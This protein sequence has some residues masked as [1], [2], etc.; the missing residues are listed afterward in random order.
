MPAQWFVHAAPALHW[1]LFCGATFLSGIAVGAVGIGG[2]FLTP[3]LIL[4]GVPAKLATTAVLTSLLPT[5]FLLCVLYWRRQQ[6]HRAGALCLTCGA[7]PG[8]ALGTA[9]LQV[10]PT[11]AMVVIVGVVASLSGLQVLAGILHARLQRRR[12]PSAQTPADEESGKG[13]RVSTDHH[14][15][16]VRPIDEDIVGARYSEDE[17]VVSPG[18]SVD[19]V[20]GGESQADEDGAESRGPTASE[21]DLESLFQSRRQRVLLFAV[22]LI[23]S[24]SSI[25]SSSGGPFTV[26]PLLFLVF[27]RGVPP[28]V[29]V[30]LGQ[31]AS[32]SISLV[33]VLTSLLIYDVD[34]DL[35][36]SLL[37][38]LS[39]SGG[40]PIGYRLGE[41]A[42]KECL[43]GVI[44]VLLIGVGLYSALDVFL[45]K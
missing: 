26:L 10:M 6:L 34:V 27:G 33:M 45:G 15:R 2:V 24:F 39:L 1:V 42:N 23:A 8:A 25:L 40:V 19:D 20:A 29:A 14:V 36:I 17:H 13:N 22:G 41:A 43:R 35:G 5:A 21:D 18:R 30:S 16:G 3:T 9:V 4:L 28:F 32:V 38:L 31:V 11:N 37:A 7:L 12:G 44:A